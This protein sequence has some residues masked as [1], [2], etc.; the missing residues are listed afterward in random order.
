VIRPRP[1]KRAVP[2]IVNQVGIWQDRLIPGYA[3]QDSHAVI[4]VQGSVAVVI[5]GRV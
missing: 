1:E 2:G 5:V 3:C 4:V